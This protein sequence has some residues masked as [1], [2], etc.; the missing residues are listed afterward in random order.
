MKE[1]WVPTVTDIHEADDAA[2]AAEFVDVIQIPVFWFDR[3][4]WSSLQQKLK[5]MSI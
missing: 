5:N 2:K 1:F 3:Q 4:T